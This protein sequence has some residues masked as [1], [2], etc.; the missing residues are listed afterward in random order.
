VKR[1]IRKV[2]VLGAGVMGSGIAAHL[3][4]ADIPTYL[5]DIVPKELSKEDEKK[6]LTNKSPAFRNKLAAMGIENALKASPAAFYVPEDARLITPGNFEDHMHWLSDADWIIEVVMENLEIKKKLF[7]KVEEVR[8]P[9]AIVSTNTSGISI[10]K[11]SEELSPEFREHF[12][13]THFFNPPR[14]MRLIELIKGKYT[15]KEIFSFMTDFCERRLGKGIVFAKDTPSFIANRIGVYGMITIMRTMLEDGYTIEEVDAITGPVMGRPKSATFRT[16]DLV[17]LDVFTHVAKNVYDNVEDEKEKK[18]FT[19]PELI[20]KMVKMNLL[21]EKVKQGFYKKV[22]TKEGSEVHSL[23]YNTMDYV[24]RKELELPVLDDLK[25]VKGLANKLKTLV[26]SEDRAGRFAWKV[27]KDVLLYS[28]GKIPEIADDILKVDEAMKW[29]FNW[30]LGPFA[31]WDAIGVKKSVERMEKEGEKIPENVKKMLLSG[32]E[33]FFGERD[34]KLRYFDFVKSDYEEV[35][36]KPQIILLPSLKERKKLIKSNSE[37]SLVDM[38]DG[39][40]C[41]EF[42]SPGNSIG[43]ELTE[44]MSYSIGEIE[45]NFEG[46]VIGNHGR[47]F[48]VGA[49][50]ML[51]LMAAQNQQWDQ[52]RLM[53]QKLQGA[54][55]RVKCSE[56]PVVAAPSGMAL[57]G[58]CEICMAARRVRA[59]VESYIGLVEV[60]VGLIPAAGG[61]KELLLRNI[62]WA[63]L[64]VPSASP[65]GSPP[66]LVPYVA[67]TFETIAMAK[68]A[69]SAKDAQRLGYLRREDRFTMNQDY[70]L[71][72]AKETVLA[73]VKEGYSPLRPKDDIRVTGR[74]GRALLELSVY[75]MKQGGYITDY[76]AHIGKKLAYVLTGGD[77]DQNTLVSEKYLLELEMEVFI[78]LCGEKKSQDRMRHML[79]TNKPL[80]N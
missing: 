46:L 17:G 18:K 39:V 36:E 52:I 30:E 40:A 13:G 79:Q 53:V 6:G 27:V 76:D 69:T 32:R 14:Y 5:L 58:G 33:R 56:K 59:Y 75:T 25:R 44:M 64:V 45:E 28:A 63:P 24:P 4:N 37:A 41:L 3:A 20:A 48:C 77:V 70:L 10:N 9:G 68:V 12:L 65:A 47:N 51:L 31:T 26:Y 7:K 55:M 38:G 43:T 35:E 22:R 2:A 34:G 78:S 1:K 74:T 62:E 19:L 8:K 66:D 49:N 54:L 50:L 72:D 21:G 60:G 11:M 57:G 15:K 80:R 42:H 16:A 71:H 29:G 73:M 23:D 67:R 61:C